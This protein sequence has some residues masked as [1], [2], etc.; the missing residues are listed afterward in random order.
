M[1]KNTIVVASGDHNIL[2]IFDFS[3]KDLLMKHSVPLIMY[4]PDTYKPK[5]EVNTKVFA[6]HKDIFPTILNIS[7][8]EAKYLKTGNNLFSAENKN[9]FGLF[10][11]KIAMDSIGCVDF[12][13]STPLFYRWNGTYN[14]L[15]PSKENPDKH[16]LELMLRSRSYI[17]SMNLFIMNDL[18]NKTKNKSLNK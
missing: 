10:S 17:A 3:D 2:Q 9:N 1:G 18:A 16:L 8:S 11:Y 12:T 7:L 13:T 4:I 14:Q 15:E 6:S 5:N